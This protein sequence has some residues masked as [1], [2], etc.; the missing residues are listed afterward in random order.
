MPILH[1]Q[2]PASGLDHD[3]FYAF[4]QNQVQTN[5]R[6]RPAL[7]SLET[8]HLLWTL[9]VSYAHAL[10]TAA[11]GVAG[12]QPSEPER[13]VPLISKLFWTPTRDSLFFL[14]EAW[15]IRAPH[16]PQIDTLQVPIYFL[17]CRT[18]F[19]N[20]FP[21]LARRNRHFPVS[22]AWAGLV[23]GPLQ[24]DA[25]RQRCLVDAMDNTLRTTVR[26]RLD[27]TKNAIDE[28][29]SSAFADAENVALLGAVERKRSGQAGIEELFRRE[30]SI[31]LDSG[32]SSLS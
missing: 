27:R 26:R 15:E 16:R 5:Q 2:H 20:G 12:L 1:D 24:L 23:G 8:D 4:C 32:P 25:I 22:N 17:D 31:T 14:W 11:R 28:V 10:E 6:S 19:F 29:D 30:G 13:L 7:S 9:T 3:V 21:E 18:C